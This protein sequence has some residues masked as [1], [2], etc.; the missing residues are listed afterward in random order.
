MTDY[1]GRFAPSPTGPLHLGSLVAAVASYLQARVNDGRWLV[2][3]ED[4]DPPREPAG[5]AAD[6]LAALDA[7]GFQYE[8]PLY[9]STRLAAYAAATE[10]LSRAGLAYPCTCSRQ[11]IKQAGATGPNGPIYPGTCRNAVANPELASLAIRFRTTN[12]PLVFTDRL[13]GLQSMRLESEHGDFLIRRRDGLVSYHLA[14]AVDDAQQGITE[15]VRG[16]D[17]LESTFPQL[18]LFEAL[19]KPRPAYMHIPIVLNAAG[20]KLS[21]QNGAAR[22]HL[23]TAAENLNKVLFFLGQKPP[24]GLRTASVNDV[25]SWAVSNWNPQI[26]EKQR[27]VTERSII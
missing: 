17:L 3:I 14:A 18:A 20:Q 7:H 26:L 25:W 15:V 27:S 9:Q 23:D 6:I 12:N 10:A 11:M 8:A 1:V 21:K 16:T 5:A 19:G 4:I 13:Q 24:I 22:L 2:R